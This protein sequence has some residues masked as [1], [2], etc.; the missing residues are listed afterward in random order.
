MKSQSTDEVLKYK[1]TNEEKEKL[2][3]VWPNERGIHPDTL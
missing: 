3:W 2:V 1:K